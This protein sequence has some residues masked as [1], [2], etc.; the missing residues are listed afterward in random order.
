MKF[1]KRLAKSPGKCDHDLTFHLNLT[2]CSG[3]LFMT[4]LLYILISVAFFGLCILYLYACER[5]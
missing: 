3:D 1:V 5:L 4:D 2:I